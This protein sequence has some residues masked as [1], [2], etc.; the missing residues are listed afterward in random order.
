VRVPGTTIATLTSDSGTFALDVPDTVTQLAVRRLGY[1]PTTVTLAATETS[2]T[3]ALAKEVF[4]L[5]AEIVTGV[6]TT[7]SSRNAANAVAVLSADQINQ[8]PTP[9][10]ESALQAKIPGALVE[11]NNGGA[12]GGGLQIQIRGITSIEADAAPLYVIDGVIVNNATVNSGINAVTEAGFGTPNNGTISQNAFDNSPNRLADINPNDIESIEVLKGSSAS[13]IYGA[14]AA[15]GVIVITTK[16]GTAGGNI[17]NVTQRLGT[18]TLANEVG[19]RTFPTL[20]SAQSWYLG[21]V[22]PGDNGTPA[23]HDDSTYIASIYDGPQDFQRQLF[24][25]GELSYETDLSV[26]G[27]ALRNTTTYYLSALS[28]Y[29]NGLMANTGYNKQSVRS[30]V[31]TSLSHDVTIGA[32]LFYSTA[33]TRRGITGNDNVG[34]APYSVLSYTPQFLNLQRQTSAG[35]PVNPFG[36]AN[37]FADAVDIQT[38]ERVNRFIA[39]GTANWNVFTVKGQTLQVVLLGGADFTQQH[40]QIYAPPSLQVEQLSPS[41]LPGV[42]TSA[43]ANTTYS[44]FSLSL[45]HTF[46]AVRDVAATTSVGIAGEQRSLNS[47]N[48]VGQ[49]LVAGQNSFTAGSVQTGFYTQT[50]LRDFSLYAQEQLLTLAE[51]LSVTGGVTAERSTDNGHINVFYTYPKVAVSYRLPQ[52]AGFVDD[53]KLRAAAGQSGTLPTYGMRFSGVVQQLVGSMNGTYTPPALGNP[54]I[55]P[56][57]NTEIE[58]GFDA[59]LLGSRAQFSATIYQKRITDVL[60]RAANAPSF[61]FSSQWV[62]GG[63]FTNQGIELSLAMTPI[64]IP[65]RF[66]WTSTSTYYRNYSVVN[67]LSV[68]AFTIFG[69]GPFGAYWIQPGRSVSEIVNLNKLSSN[70]TPVQ[71][72]DGQPAFTMGFANDFTAGP[73][74]L[75]T[76]LDWKYGGNT[77][78]FTNLYY[79]T[80][81]GLLAD[82][83]LSAKRLASLNAGGTPYVEPGGY[84]KLREVT[85]S[86]DLPSRWVRA[87]PRVRLTSVKLSLSGRNLWSSFKYSGLDPEVSSTGAA[88]IARNVDITQ[89]PPARSYFVSLDL[90]L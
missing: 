21:H 41:G 10:L 61:G 60:L 17:W 36:T 16:K 66:T 11:Q 81:P 23:A 5:D 4:H 68:P 14:N 72:G 69:G 40:D 31:S 57:T 35:W 89:Y 80:G 37:P 34:I 13:A 53:F 76:V 44:N 65:N 79:D 27:A 47:T 70:G 42:A 52:F 20:G 9:T 46:T 71:V 32:N 84:L 38:P 26:R 25:G 73:V 49:N 33:L 6:A 85:L 7:I 74:H 24:G 18:Y 3:I 51:R 2:I 1:H 67:S 90:G 50:A 87:I 39:G 62:N 43:N 64:Q 58:T 54:D 15:S 28:K 22:V 82:S 78:N 56:E 86:Y 45:I 88:N 29:D 12:P 83:A 30:N 63:E 59:T 48:N 8:T 19:L 75:A 55:K 77:I